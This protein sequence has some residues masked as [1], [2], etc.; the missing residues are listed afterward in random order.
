[1]KKTVNLL[2][3]NILSSL[4]SLALPIMATSFIQMAYNMTDMIWLGRI[5]SSAVTSVGTAGMY[6]WFSNG[7]AALAKI[8]GQVKVGHCIGAKEYDR[9]AGYTAAAFQ[10]AV[11]L[12][13]VYGL[14]CVLFSG[15]L[16]GFFRLTSPEVISDARIYLIITCGLLIFS[17]LN[18]VFA[19]V[20]T[21]MGRSLHLL[22]ATSVGLVI[23]IILDPVLIFGL[24]PFPRLEVVGAAIA[25]VFAQAI[26][27]F[28]FILLAV[29]NTQ[30]FQKQYIFKIS[31]RPILKEIVVIGLPACVQSTIFTSISM[32]LARIIASFGESAIAVQKIG[33]QIESVSW[34][35]S[36][37]FSSA[38][39]S[40]VAQNYG[41]K[42]YH[43]IRKGYS[44]SMVLAVVWGLICTLLLVFAPAPLFGFFLPDPDLLPMGTTYLQILGVSQLFMCI[45]IMTAGAFSGLGKTLPP[46]IVGTT[47]TAARIP[48]AFWLITTPLALDGVWWSIT[49]SSILKGLVLVSWFLLYL[50]NQKKLWI[51][52]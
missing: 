49:I 44:T 5:G 10:I 22:L 16:I 11:L 50:K 26:V 51:D 45:E 47:L 4:V 15:P 35:I 43:R 25:T 23:N 24:G 37:G 40:F 30:L 31:P 9:A 36:D 14:G 6:L 38:V 18:Q 48:L 3:S 28:I 39:N 12:S 13:I 52:H 42:K 17:F 33:S 20:L 46:S 29:K 32:V 19:G 1:M 21:A 34:M 8:G 41:A 7:L 2:E 27:T